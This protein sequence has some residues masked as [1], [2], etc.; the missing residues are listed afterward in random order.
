[1][2]FCQY[3]GVIVLAIYVIVVLFTNLGVCVDFL[4]YLGPESPTDSEGF[5]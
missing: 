4:V 1:M 3:G 2:R 5:C